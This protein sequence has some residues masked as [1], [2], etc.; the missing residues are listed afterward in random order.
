MRA[1][2]MP[3]IQPINTLPAY[4]SQEE[5]AS[6]VAS[7][8]TSFNDIPAVIKHKE[9]NVT[10]AVDPPIPDFSGDE[11][12]GTLYILTRRVF[13]FIYLA[14]NPTHNFS[15]EYPSITLHAVSRGESGP[16]IYCQL[17]ESAGAQNGTGEEEYSEM[18]ELSIIPS[19]PDSLERIFETLSMCA[20]LHPDNDVDEDDGL[21]DA[22]IDPNTTNFETF[23]GG[24]DEELSEVGRAALAHLESIIYN[25]FEDA[26]ETTVAEGNKEKSET[27]KKTEDINP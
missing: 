20:S 27:E 24:E 17:D 14:V 16:S 21:D 25:P 11:L 7:T 6:I 8:P 5:Y 12:K 3:A 15:V 4:V 13:H 1:Q 9:D 23:T 26:E 22:F 18:R 19:A 10:I 2:E